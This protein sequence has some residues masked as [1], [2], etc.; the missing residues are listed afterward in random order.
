MSHL[1]F[2]WMSQRRLTLRPVATYVHIVI[3]VRRFVMVIRLL[4]SLLFGRLSHIYARG[5]APGP[6]LA[7]SQHQI[8]SFNARAIPYVLSMLLFICSLAYVQVKP[9]SG[10]LSVA[11]VFAP[12]HANQVPRWDVSISSSMQI[13]PEE[14]SIVAH[15]PN[16]ARRA[17]G[18]AS[19]VSIARCCIA[20]SLWNTR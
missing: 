7:T 19:R 12:L 4:M 20:R 18:Q 8:A 14:R 5:V 1:L 15:Q 6:G 3:C 13:M 16:Q 10:M 9:I 17:S 11:H 2:G